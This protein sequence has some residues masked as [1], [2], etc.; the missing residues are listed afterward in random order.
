MYIASSRSFYRKM[1]ENSS[2]ERHNR[3][4]NRIQAIRR[5]DLRTETRILCSF[6]EE[7]RE[8]HFLHWLDQKISSNGDHFISNGLVW[9]TN[10][11]FL[12]TFGSKR[13]LNEL[14]DEWMKVQIKTLVSVTR[15]EDIIIGSWLCLG[16]FLLWNAYFGLPPVKLGREREK[17]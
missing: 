17:R 7:K 8:K 9:W 13:L 12:L 10:H 3:G 6:S 15:R 2:M 4:W 16:Q 11:A 1:T 14:R 5:R